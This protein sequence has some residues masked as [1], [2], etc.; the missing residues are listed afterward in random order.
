VF[1]LIYFVIFSYFFCPSLVLSLVCHY[2]TFC[3][4]PIDVAIIGVRAKPSL[5]GQMLNF[6]GR[7]QQPEMKNVFIKRQKN[8]IHTVQQDEVVKIRDFC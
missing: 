5:F 7:S 3:P 6:S 4:Q 2:A 8:G 1:A